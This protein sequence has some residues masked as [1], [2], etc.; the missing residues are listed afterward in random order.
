ML[1]WIQHEHN[2]TTSYTPAYDLDSLPCDPPGRS[3][4]SWGEL[5]SIDLV[6]ETF[7]E[8]DGRPNALWKRFTDSV[9]LYDFSS[10][11][12]NAATP[13]M[14][15]VM[16]F[17]L[18]QQS[19]MQDFIAGKGSYQSQGAGYFKSTADVATLAGKDA[20]GVTTGTEISALRI[21]ITVWDG[22]SH[23]RLNTVVTPTGSSRAKIITAL[24][25]SSE[26]E[27]STTSTTNSTTSSSSSS[28][29][30]TR[31]S[32]SSSSST[33]KALNYPFVFLEMLEN[34]EISTPPAEPAVS[35]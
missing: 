26:R 15:A 11:N 8:Q 18:N 24:A 9:S 23:F 19:R 28:S 21:I 14:M 10:T 4:R 35:Q 25:T 30:S 16:G 34:D 12:I 31:T 29:G 1:Y 3:L 6:R 2:P 20:S 5:A 17:D 13:D 32:T 27:S 33:P 7:F 22:R